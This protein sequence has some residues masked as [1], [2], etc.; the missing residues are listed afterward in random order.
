MGGLF[1]S[2]KQ[3]STSQVNLPGWA[4]SGFEAI[5]T[6]ATDLMDRPYQPF[7]GQRVA[8]M[9]DWTAAGAGAVQSTAGY[10]PGQVTPGMVQ[11]PGAVRPNTVRAGQVAPGSVS[12]ERVAPGSLAG[13]DLSA[14]YD[15]Y[16]QQ[17]IDA[18][19]ADIDRSTRVAQAGR[20]S[21]GVQ[22][23]GFGGF[24]D[25]SAVAAAEIERA[26]IDA[27]ARTAAGLRSQ[28]FQRAQDLAVGDISRDFQG[29]GQNAQMGLQAGL[30]N[31]QTGLAGQQFNVQSGMQAGLANQQARLQAQQFSA[32]QQMQAGLANQQAGLAGQQFNVQSGMQGAALR[33]NAGQTLAGLG[34]VDRGVRQAGL[35]FDYQQFREG[36]DDP[37]LKAQWASGVLGSAAAPYGAN[38]TQ[39]TPGPSAFSQMAGAALTGA[40]IYA[41]SDPGEKTDKRRIGTDPATGLG[42]WSYRYKGDSK[43]YPKVVGPMADEVEERY[44]HLVR[45]VADRRVVDMAGLDA[46][47]GGLGDAPGYSRGG[48]TNE[49]VGARLFPSMR[50][51]LPP[52][53]DGVAEAVPVTD[54]WHG[55]PAVPTALPDAAYGVPPSPF[56]RM[57]P[58]DMGEFNNPPEV[59]AAPMDAADLGGFNEQ[60][61][62]API[63]NSPLVERAL[64]RLRA[65]QGGSRGGAAGRVFPGET[66]PHAVPDAMPYEPAGSLVPVAAQGGAAPAAASAGAEGG[67]NWLR[68]FAD[69]LV[70]PDYAGPQAMMQAGLAMMASRNPNWAGA[71]GEGAS[72]GLRAAERAREAARPLQHQRRQAQEFRDFLTNR[73]DP[74]AVSPPLAPRRPGVGAAPP[75]SPRMT[76]VA[77]PGGVE[78]PAELRDAFEAASRETGI[79]VPV[80]VATAR[81]ESNFNPAA[82]GQAGEVGVMQILPSTAREPGFGLSGV[83]PEALRDPAANIMFGARYLRARAGEGAD[84]SQ[85]EVLARALRAYNGGG[86]PNYVQNVQRWMPQGAER[87]PGASERP[88]GAPASRAGGEQP[89][90]EPTVT[91]HGRPFTRA[92]LLTLATTMPDNEMAQNLV[93][94]GLPMLNAEV[95][96]R[97]GAADRALARQENADLRRDL[98]ASRAERPLPTDLAR[99]RAERDALPPGH[100]DRPS[101]DAAI[102]R[103][104][105]EAAAERFTPAQVVQLRRDATTAAR[106]E[107]QQLEFDSERDRSGWINQRARDLLG[108]WGAPEAWE[109]GR[110][111]GATVPA[112]GGGGRPDATAAPAEPR[113]VP[114]TRDPLSQPLSEGQSKANLFGLMMQQSEDI[115]AGRPIQTGGVARPPVEVPNDIRLQIWRNLPEGVSNWF[116]DENSQRYFN[117]LRLFAAGVL[118]KE[119]GAAFAPFELL[120]VQS[121]FFPMAGDTP[122]VMAQKATSRRLVLEAMQAEVPGGFRRGVQDSRPRPAGQGYPEA[123]VPAPRP[124]PGGDG[125]RPPLESFIGS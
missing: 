12:A 123:P 125:N 19:M 66:P 118:R 115:L 95:A 124:S 10:Q 28:G 83:D 44:P 46:M 100:P 58:G 41:M 111:G 85:P 53:I 80:L 34:E 11:A 110:G 14:Y 108:E 88:S 24:G 4:N 23:A 35:D 36:R 29:Q 87:P 90:G 99:L 27:K 104:S 50:R 32:G 68:R 112:S 78:P 60:R 121:R 74:T 1:K 37:F 84:F 98:A 59:R 42:I 33:A 79:P 77:V 40:S 67:Q 122:E 96:R 92:D 31:Q 5:G 94:M 70:D 7:Q 52:I 43:R 71:I 22:A 9:S 3:T 55:T 116:M 86:D 119:T 8:G 65:A 102:R 51:P 56:G 89:Q 21:G 64:A 106:A 26:G 15:P 25:R 76:S 72:V 103:S 18:S 49:P 109:T 45:R 38:I 2:S 105:G 107:A 81:Q 82:T 47:R 13:R 61:Q 16:Q 30:A 101:Y 20:A 54:A 117:A 91:L 6:R 97:E 39:T 62:D 17:V 120:D 57:A 113:I 114:R 73:P 93:R 48:I 69:R 75:A 63:V